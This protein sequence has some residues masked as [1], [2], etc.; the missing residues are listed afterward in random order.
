[1]VACIEDCRRQKIP[2]LPPDI[3]LSQV[4]FAIEQYHSPRGQTGAVRFGLVAIKGLGEGVVEAIIREREEN[5]PFTHLFEF[6]ERLKPA[7]INRLGVEALIR[8]GAMA[9]IDKNRQKLLQFAEAALAY[10]ESAT[11]NRLAGQDSLFGEGEAPEVSHYPVLPETDMPSR[12]DLLAMEKEVLG[13]YVSD[14]PL[15]GHERIVEQASS[16]SC[17]AIAELD[18]GIQVRVA[19]VI[20]A[21]RTIVTKSKGEKM[22]SL[23]IED[24]TG[25]A[26]VICF[27]A[28]YAKLGSSLIKDQVV[29]LTGTIMHR[30][31]PGNGGEKTIEIR[32]EEVRPLEPALELAVDSSAGSVEVRIRAAT[33]QQVKAFRELLERHPGQ[34]S[35]VWQVLPAED[36]LPLQLSAYVDASNGFVDEVKALLKHAEVRVRHHEAAMLVSA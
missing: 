6:C 20:A 28:T 16:H 14:H 18:E 3:N 5:G 34:Y 19:G 26:S 36:Y 8:S 22:A 23:V 10:A 1:M 31:R 11:R 4:D 7:G 21:M 2:V 33:E 24:F 35:V 25:Q 27:P 15:R 30:E 13:I 29:Q 32:L 9:P 17:S 12:G